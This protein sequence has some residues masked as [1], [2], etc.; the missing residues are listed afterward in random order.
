MLPLLVMTLCLAQAEPTDLSSGADLQAWRNIG[1]EPSQEQLHAFLQTYRDSPLAE[2]AV[3]RLEAKGASIPTEKLEGVIESVL[4]HDARLA[5]GPVS[6]AIAPVSMKP[7]DS[8][9]RP[10]NP[11]API[12]AAE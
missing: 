10:A 3:R 7:T 9:D 5:A 2:L 6:V 1:A 4:N 8:S 11:D 12:A